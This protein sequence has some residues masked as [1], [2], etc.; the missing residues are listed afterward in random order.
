M[1]YTP[2]ALAVYHLEQ[3][4]TPW[5]AAELA[6]RRARERNP[7]NQAAIVVVNKSGDYGESNGNSWQL[8][9]LIYERCRPTGE[10]GIFSDKKILMGEYA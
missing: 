1:R 9:C 6:L 3:G 2:A 8:S 7:K 4:R 5:E 10:S